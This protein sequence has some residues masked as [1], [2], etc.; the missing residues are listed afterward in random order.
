MIVGRVE[1]HGGEQITLTLEKSKNKCYTKK[2]GVLMSNREY[3]RDMLSSDKTE[4][5]GSSPEWPTFVSKS[6]SDLPPVVVPLLT[7]LP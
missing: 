4:V 7:S 1:I 5:S 2:K 6:R 3:Y